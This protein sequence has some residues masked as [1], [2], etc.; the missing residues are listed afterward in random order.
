R[1]R[2]GAPPAGVRRGVRADRAA[3]AVLT[4][5]LDSGPAA[6]ATR[7]PSR[8]MLTHAARM[9]AITA[10]LILCTLLPYLPGRYDALAA[11]LSVAAR[12]AGMAGLLLVPIGAAW[13]A[14]EL[15]SRRGGNGAPQ[16]RPGR[17]RF[18]IAA[19]VAGSA[20]CL[21]ASLGALLFAGVSAGAGALALSAYGVAKLARRVPA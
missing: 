1:V 4:R 2:V 10:L 11:P 3:A 7:D 12:L 20:V 6:T 21:V 9:G 15:W 19:L 13:L 5:C 16:S 8:P 17:R 14:Y 18:A